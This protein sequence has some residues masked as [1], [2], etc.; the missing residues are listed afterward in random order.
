L[1]APILDMPIL[2]RSIL[3]APR[4]EAPLPWRLV[5]FFPLLV[6]KKSSAELRLNLKPK[7]AFRGDLDA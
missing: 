4:L 2:D 6:A 1:G 3:E 7:I 5:R